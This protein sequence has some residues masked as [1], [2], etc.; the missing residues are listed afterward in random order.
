[1]SIQSATHFRK[2]L[3]MDLTLFYQF[4]FFNLKA[5]PRK[6]CSQ[7][8]ETAWK[9]PC[10]R[11]GRF[12][13]SLTVKEVLSHPELDPE[14]SDGSFTEEEAQVC[15]NRPGLISIA[16]WQRV[17]PHLFAE[18]TPVWKCRLIAVHG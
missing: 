9:K 7:I 12:V 11:T 13:L 4:R 10:D 1:M 16:G 3:Y 2:M 5:D 6:P 17:T 14:K 15:Q 18:P 8:F